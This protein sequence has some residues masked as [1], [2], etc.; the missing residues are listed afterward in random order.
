VHKTTYEITKV[1]THVKQLQFS[2]LLFKY[3][4]SNNHTGVKPVEPDMV[5]FN[6]DSILG[7]SLGHFFCAVWL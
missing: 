7:I 2:A 6:K 4:F 5:V 1:I 3:T